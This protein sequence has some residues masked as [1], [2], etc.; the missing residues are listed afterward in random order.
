MVRTLTNHLS[1]PVLLLSG[2]LITFLAIRFEWNY[3]AVGIGIFL[4]TAVYIL[5]L[6]QIIPLKTEWLSKRQERLT[7]V[8]HLLSTIVFDALGKGFALWLM[9]FVHSWYA[10]NGELWQAMPFLL[11][12]GLANILGELVPYVYHRISHIG[13]STSAVSLF[14]WKVHAIH[15]LPVSL[16][17]FKTSWMHPVNMFL[18][19]FLKYGILILLGFDAAIMFSVGVTHVI[20]AY[21]SHANIDAKTR[22]LDYLIVTPKIH[23]F[24]H[25]KKLEEAKNFGNILPF[26]DLVFGTFYNRAGT[27]EHVGTTAASYPYPPQKAFL[28]QWAFPLYARKRCCFSVENNKD[29]SK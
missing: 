25:S 12:Y 28:K 24:H 5:L 10:P 14:L 19:T 7:D 4:F 21:L 23:Q 2:G 26:W 17:W 6:E 15:H 11:V 27:V 1:V 16:N 29:I 20:I 18:N 8:K 3:E 22:I 9:L 13:K